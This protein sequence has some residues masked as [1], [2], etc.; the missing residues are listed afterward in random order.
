MDDIDNDWQEFCDMQNE[1]RHKF[2]NFVKPMKPIAAAKNKD[3][4]PIL[5]PKSNALYNMIM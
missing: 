1:E 2:S 4:T 5:T 3:V